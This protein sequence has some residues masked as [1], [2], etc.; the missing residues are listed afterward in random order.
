[1]TKRDCVNKMTQVLLNYTQTALYDCASRTAMSVNCTF[2][3]TLRNC[4]INTTRMALNYMPMTLCECACFNTKIS[5][6][7]MKGWRHANAPIRPESPK[8]NI[9]I[10]T[11]CEWVTETTIMSFKYG[12]Q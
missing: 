3:E 4:F 5:L 7:Y 8:S 9:D 6:N 10:L 2:K 1:M 11:C 12:A